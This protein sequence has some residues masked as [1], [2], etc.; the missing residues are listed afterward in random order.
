MEATTELVN[1]G[2]EIAT[3]P[4]GPFEW[5]EYVERFDGKD[6]DDHADDSL[7]TPLIYGGKSEDEARA[8]V[9]RPETFPF[10]HHR[11][12]RRAVSAWEV[13]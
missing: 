5:G 4:D 7:W 13:Q 9:E 2:I 12:I 6:G 10:R 11:V 1:E 8:A 3:R